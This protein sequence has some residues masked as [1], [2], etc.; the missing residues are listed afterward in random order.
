MK[1]F[2]CVIL[3]CAWPVF[4]QPAGDLREM[5]EGLEQAQPGSTEEQQISSGL[6]AMGAEAIPSLI[7]AAQNQKITWEQAR[8][9]LHDMSDDAS[10]AE[11]RQLLQD[12]DDRVARAAAFSVE[13]DS[14]SAPLLQSLLQRVQDDEGRVEVA[15][16]L[17]NARPDETSAEAIFEAARQSANARVQLF[18]LIPR[19]WRDRLLTI[20]ERLESLAAALPDGAETYDIKLDSPASIEK[21]FG[22]DSATHRFIESHPREVIEFMT[23]KLRETGACSAAL[24]LGYFRDKPSISELQRW[25]LEQNYYEEWQSEMP[26]DLDPKH[27]PYHRCYEEAIVHIT[28]KPLE[29]VVPLN[30]ALTNTQIAKYHQGIMAALYVLKR[31]RPDVAVSETFRSFR[32][33]DRNVN[34]CV[35]ASDLL[36]DASSAAQVTEALGK[37]D[38]TQENR[39]IYHCGELGSE[40]VND[41]FLQLRFEKEKLVE[42]SFLQEKSATQRN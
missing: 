40:V 30:P 23:Y 21:L 7:R 42:R 35:N 34:V 4:A 1:R 39:W 27:Y 38:R 36:A 9:I 17:W 33:K 12:P 15:E 16:F 5:I 19:E 10:R 29:E 24:T 3:F 14:N 28:G 41:V 11:L 31:L 25:Y 6:V 8:N 18:N 22:S 2:L 26:H 32:S 37:P 13:G 20:Q